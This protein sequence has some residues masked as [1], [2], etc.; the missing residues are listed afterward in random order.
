MYPARSFRSAT[1]RVSAPRAPPPGRGHN[2]HAL[3]DLR[4]H[5]GDLLVLVRRQASGGRA[6][7]SALG[8]LRPWVGRAWD[9]A[10]R[11]GV[12]GLRLGESRCQGSNSTGSRP[13]C[14]RQCAPFSAIGRSTRSRRKPLRFERI[15][16][17]AADSVPHRE[18][19]G[20][21]R[22][23][24]RHRNAARRG[25]SPRSGGSVQEPRH[26]VLD[27]PDPARRDHPLVR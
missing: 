7:R 13:R 27:D 26:P 16:S 3:A 10:L 12:G 9:R 6:A 8:R 20:R 15:S 19:L 24:L 11:P 5:S 2:N 4:G 14:W 17:R 18:L 23:A 22:A 1:P 25:F 21:C